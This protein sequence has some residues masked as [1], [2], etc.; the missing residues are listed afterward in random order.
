MGT[1]GTT[2]Q[3]NGYCGLGNVEGV[4]DSLHARTA[5][6]CGSGD[7][8]FDQLEEAKNLVDNPVIF[9]ANDVGMF[10]EKLDHWVSLHLDNIPRWMDVR[11]AH[12]RGEKH[13]PKIHS[14]SVGPKVDYHWSGLTPTF[15]LSGYFAMQIAHVMGADRIIL[16]GCPGDRTRRFFDAKPR[17]VFGYGN[18]LQNSDKGIMIQLKNEMERVPEFKKKV[19]SMS[20]FT[21][22]F[23]GGIK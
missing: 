14:C 17:D 1:H 12:R 15:A 21:R 10:I 19:R 20:G 9:A 13:P 4:L 23:F 11:F 16:C 5:I 8:V 3:R 2:W 6:V 22:E 18:G 7:G